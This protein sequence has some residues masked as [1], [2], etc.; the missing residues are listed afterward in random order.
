MPSTV[1]KATIKAGDSVSDM[2]QIRDQVVTAIT[3]DK[4]C[5]VQVLGAMEDGDAFLPLGVQSG[6]PDEKIDLTRGI[7]VFSVAVIQGVQYV[8]FLL[9]Q[10]AAEDIELKVMVR[11]FPND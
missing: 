11:S 3:A 6:P 7:A 2:I 5:I 9:D 8:E 10:P 1:F 4:P